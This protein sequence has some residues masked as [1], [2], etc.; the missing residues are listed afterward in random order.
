MTVQKHRVTLEHIQAL[1][2][3]FYS[4]HNNFFPAPLDYKSRTA[5]PA[6]PAFFGWRI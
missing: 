5:L 3:V 4:Q 6:A 2:F 1:G